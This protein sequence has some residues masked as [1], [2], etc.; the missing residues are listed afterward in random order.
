[1]TRREESNRS[2]C[3]GMQHV[4][5]TSCSTVHR[6]LALCLGF[7]GYIFVCGLTPKVC[8][9]GVVTSVIALPGWTERHLSFKQPGHWAAAT[10]KSISAHILYPSPLTNTLTNK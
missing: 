6:L 2:S 7:V 5:R 4:C 1:V 3:G 9:Q 10:R 8:T